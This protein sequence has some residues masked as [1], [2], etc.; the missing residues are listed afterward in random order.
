MFDAY[1]MALIGAELNFAPEDYYRMFIEPTKAL[2]GVKDEL[3]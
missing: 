2:K 1:E 3:V